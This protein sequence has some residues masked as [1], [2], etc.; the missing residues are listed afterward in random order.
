MRDLNFQVKEILLRNRDGSESTRANRWRLCMS[1]CNDLRQLGFKNL[2]LHNLKQKHVKALING[3]QE[4]SLKPGTQKNYM[5]ALRWVCEKIGK[6]NLVA[7]SNDALG[8]PDRSNLPDASKGKDVI[9]AQLAHISDPYVVMALR[10]QA[11]FGLR[12]EESMKFTPSWADKGDKIT[13]KRSWCK[14]GREREI[15]VRTDDQRAVLAEAR[16]LAGKG[17]LIPA[18]LRYV[19]QLQIYKS[20]CRKVGIGF[21]HGHRHFYAQ[22]RYRELTGWDCPVRGGPT[23]KQ[24]TAAQKAI[25]R[26]ARMTVSAELGHGREQITVNYLGR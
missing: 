16:A 1:I 2:D 24:L 19:D 14:G 17:S 25:D 4:R 21:A 7:R 12:R 8:I 18:E 10:L 6:S 3:W 5:A 13:L 15:P 20:Q 23:A 22:E 11:M 9:P 26:T